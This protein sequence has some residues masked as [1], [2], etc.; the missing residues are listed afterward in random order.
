M[1][2]W[3]LQLSLKRAPLVMNQEVRYP[4]PGMILFESQTRACQEAVK[5]SHSGPS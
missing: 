1:P 4:F 5:P 2:A 3:R